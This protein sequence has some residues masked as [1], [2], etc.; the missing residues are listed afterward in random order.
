MGQLVLT[1]KISEKAIALAERGMY[2]FEVPTSTNKIEVAKAIEAAFKVNVIDVNMMITKGKLKRFKQILGRQK[3]IKKAIVRLK[4][5][6]KIS[7]FEG[8]Q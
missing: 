6:Q 8:A 2:V 5:G 4:A 1:P 3:D 7:L